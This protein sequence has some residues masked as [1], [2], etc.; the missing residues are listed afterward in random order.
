MTAWLCV[1]GAIVSL[2][3]CLLATPASSQE[4]QRGGREPQTRDDSV[5]RP[6]TLPPPPVTAYPVELLGLLATPAPRGP[7]TLI[8]SIAV[9]EEYNDN[10]FLNNNDRRSDFITGFTPAFSLFVNRPNYEVS[11]GYAFT[12]EI[13]AEERSLS[14]PFNRQAFVGTGLFRA[15]PQLTLRISDTYAYDRNANVT[16]Q[17]PTGRQESWSNTFTPAMTWQMTPR[18]S[19]T[20][21]A[22][23]TATRFPGNGTGI[24]SDTYSFQT[25]FGYAFTPRFTGTIG[26]SFTYLDLE[27]QDNATTHNPAVGFTY[28]LTPTLTLVMSGGPAITDIGGD[29]TISPAGAASLT[30]IFRWGSAS[31]QY[32]RT[33]SAA[34]GFGGATDS[35][36]ASGTLAVLALRD[37]VLAFTP[38]YT[39]SASLSSRQTTRVDVQ[40]FA[41]TLGGLYRIAQYVAVFAGYSF[42]HQR[43]GGSSSQQANIDQN[44]VRIGLQ[45]GYPIHFD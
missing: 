33:V 5:E 9:S 11:A 15:T 4:P 13:Y 1:G 42:L 45:F 2:V 3:V 35:Q 26:Y 24:D 21:G 31:V 38:A 41:L 14:G 39:T 40:T 20:V 7:L 8:P 25:T 10:I 34:G 37:L 23:Y 30:Q 19:V 44:R 29:T 17:G 43:T 12:S 6:S 18:S 27:R 28:Y 36:T 32:S 16:A 22:G